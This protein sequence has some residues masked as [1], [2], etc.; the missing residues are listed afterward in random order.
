MPIA[1]RRAVIAGAALAALIPWASV[2]QAADGKLYVV[3]ELVA[4]PG[5]EEALRGALSQFAPTVPSE[6]GCLAYQLFEDM[7]QPG[8]FLTYETWADEAALTAHLTAPKMKAAAPTMAAIL[9]KP[10]GLTMLKRLV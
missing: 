9:A 3:A 2:A 4:K 7:K 1:G 8:R 6:P 10:F 5:K